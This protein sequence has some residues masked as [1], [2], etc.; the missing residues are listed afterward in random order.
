MRWF[1]NFAQN[2]GPWGKGKIAV[3]QVARIKSAFC[4][5]SKLHKNK[6]PP[7]QWLGLK[8]HHT[9]IDP[10]QIKADRTNVENKKTPGVFKNWSGLGRDSTW[11]KMKKF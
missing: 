9:L 8:K 10:L 11:E 1:E 2:V 3:R 4:P 7:G 6:M 5:S